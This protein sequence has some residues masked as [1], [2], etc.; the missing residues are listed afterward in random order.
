MLNSETLAGKRKKKKKKCPLALLYCAYYQA[1]C[2]TSYHHISTKQQISASAQVPL[3]NPKV[4][5]TNVPQTSKIVLPVCPSNLKEHFTCPNMCIKDSILGGC[6][7]GPNICD[8]VM[9]IM[10][11]AWHLSLSFCIST[12]SKPEKK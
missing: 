8:K 6:R 7:W 4:C 11:I 3:S 9:A 1:E 12:Q 5:F 10:L 2:I